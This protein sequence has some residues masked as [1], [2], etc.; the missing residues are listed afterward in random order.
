MKSDLS[1]NCQSLVFSFGHEQL[2]LLALT[3]YC[4]EEWN[5]QKSEH[6]LRHS[7]IV[8]SSFLSWTF[9][10]CDNNACTSDCTGRTETFTHKQ[11]RRLAAVGGERFE[12]NRTFYVVASRLIFVIQ[13]EN[14]D[15]FS[16][17]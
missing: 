16:K 1:L 10:V 6:D 4:T 11:L 2:H 5:I 8:S 17:R 14:Y 3:I 15:G 9:S 13:A 7:L 12:A